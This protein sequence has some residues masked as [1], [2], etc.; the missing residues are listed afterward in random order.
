MGVI[1]Q[2]EDRHRMTLKGNNGSELGS[3]G[4][5]LWLG[6]RQNGDTIEWWGEWPRLR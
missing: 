2:R 1:V 3:D 6:M 4:V 5:V